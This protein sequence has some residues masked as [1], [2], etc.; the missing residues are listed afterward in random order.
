MQIQ[1]RDFQFK[2]NL[3]FNKALLLPLVIALS[4]CGGSDS[5][6]GKGGD[7]GEI[8]STYKIA[9][10]LETIYT[11]YSKYLLSSTDPDF[12]DMTMQITTI[13]MPKKVLNNQQVL[14]VKTLTSSYVNGRL[15]ENDESIGYMTTNPFKIVGAEVS[16]RY[17]IDSHAN[18]P[19]T[20][21]VGESGAFFTTTTYNPQGHKVATTMRTWNLKPKSND[22]ANLCTTTHVTRLWLSGVDRQLSATACY[23]INANG[24]VYGLK[25]I[26]VTVP[27]D[28]RARV[29]NFTAK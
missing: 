16:G 24:I 18:L 23:E 27:M 2:S 22:R 26:S 11:T 12:K 14:P 17:V 10:P 4:A 21:K 8:I 7:S 6:S 20:A 13:P 9:E 3:G 5:D 1:F 28:G 19:K 15:E 29:V 25:T